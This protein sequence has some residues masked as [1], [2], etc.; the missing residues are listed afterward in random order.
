MLVQVNY[1]R[2]YKS[3]D[4]GPLIAALCAE[5]DRHPVD[6]QRLLVTLDWLQY[7]NNFRVPVAALPYQDE[8]GAPLPGLELAVDVRRLA[9][10]VQQ[11]VASALADVGGSA[12]DGDR[13]YL[14]DARPPS[15]SM[16]W[17]FNTAYW[18]NLSTWEAV[19]KR[20]FLAALPGGVTDGVNPEFWRDRLTEFVVLLD[21]LDRRRILPEEIFVLELGVGNGSQAKVW[22]DTFR[23]LCQERG[24]DYYGRVRYL[25]TDFSHDVLRTARATVADHAEKV[26]GLNVDV[27]DPQDALAFLRYKILFIHSCNLYDN[28][29]TDEIARRDG[30]LYEVRVRAYLPA[31]AVEEICGRYDLIPSQVPTTIQRLLRI[32]P[33]YFDDSERGVSFWSETWEALKLEERYVRIE[34]PSSYHIVPGGHGVWLEDLLGSTAGDLRLHLST[35]AVRSFAHT[36][37]LLHPNG[38][39]QVQDLF[40]TKLEDFQGSFR[41]PGKM[42][43]SIVNWLNGPLF[44]LVGAHMG[45]DVRLDPF[46]YRERSNIVVLTTSPKA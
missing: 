34:E 32:G 27:I 19:F 40:T 3:V 4:V 14:E 6:P 36:L 7:R 33:E 5:L 25:M 43:G 30:A 41:G 37:P 12:T 23:D 45:Y 13:L 24:R 9:A 10:D 38:V 31:P 26:S 15:Q 39:F 46:R 35:G 20:D 42:D 28:L 21:D 29:P 17:S 1:L 18:R 16:I 2:N 44:Q 8:R 11:A 22:L